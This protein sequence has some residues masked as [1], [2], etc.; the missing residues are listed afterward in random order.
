MMDKYLRKNHGNNNAVTG[1]FITTYYFE[2]RLKE[3]DDFIVMLADALINPLFNM[4]DIKRELYLMNSEVSNRMLDEKNFFMYDFL[5]EIGNKDSTIFF[6]GLN[7]QDVEALDLEKVRENV[8]AFFAKHYSANNMQLVII[9]DQNGGNL[10]KKA[11]SEFVNIPNNN[12]VREYFNTTETRIKP[13]SD[14]V[15][16]T[17][18]YRKAGTDTPSIKLVFP[19]DSYRTDSTFLAPEFFCI[20]LQYFSE[21]SFY[22]KLMQRKIVERIKCQKLLEN[23]TDAVMLVRFFEL[24]NN[25]RAYSELIFSFFEFVEQLKKST[26]LREVFG[27][28]SSLSKFSFLFNVENKKLGLAE[29]ESNL[30]LRAMEYSQNL[31]EFPNFDLFKG[32]KVYDNYDQ[33]R[34]MALLE[35]ISLKNAII[36]IENDAF[37]TK[38]DATQQS[39]QDYNQEYRTDTGKPIDEGINDLKVSQSISFSDDMNLDRSNSSIPENSN[40]QLKKIRMLEDNGSLDNDGTKNTIQLK[41]E[42]ADNISEQ[43]DKNQHNIKYE[44]NTF[45]SV[46][47]VS[48]KE[49]DSFRKEFFDNAL[50]NV[51]LTEISA[52]KLSSPFAKR[53]IPETMNDKM[54]IEIIKEDPLFKMLEPVDTSF[55]NK[56]EIIT[57]CNPP[58][59]LQEKGIKLL[60]THNHKRFEFYEE[61]S[62]AKW[63]YQL[64]NDSQ[65]TQFIKTDFLY[66]LIFEPQ[67]QNSSKNFDQKMSDMMKYKYCLEGDFTI[68]TSDKKAQIIQEENDINVWYKLYRKELQPKYV[69]IIAIKSLKYYEQMIKDP[70]SRLEIS[71]IMDFFCKYLERHL[72]L[73]FPEMFMQ[74]YNFNCRRNNFEFEFTITGVSNKLTDFINTIR[75]EIESLTNESNINM[76][77]YERLI[78]RRTQIL[79]NFRPQTA[80]KLAI[81]YLDNIMDALHVDYSKKENSYKVLQITNSIRPQIIA[82]SIINMYE[83]YKI[84]IFTCGN[85]NKEQTM[86][87]YNFFKKNLGDLTDSFD[88]L[89]IRKTREYYKKLTLK[90]N[91]NEH[92]MIRI[93]NP[94]K[95]DTNNIYLTYFKLGQLDKK[96]FMFLKVALFYLKEKFFTKFRITF[97]LGYVATAFYVDYN[98]VS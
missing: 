74:G 51:V 58:E 14:D 6:D 62:K 48:D 18:F 72:S 88:H 30:F 66:D 25:H 36:I 31:F 82:Q 1:D 16:G 78:S 33:D 2:M 92:K 68:D 54:I 89:N 52:N 32:E 90:F 71:V 4:D 91:M 63:L 27:S 13:F 45:I 11:E 96:E 69:A 35:Q 57:K 53:K 20:V 47:N 50:D 94:F 73:K 76:I 8:L 15:V 70:E 95:E 44:K 60:N 59:S 22:Y 81:Y 40:P 24:G 93:E 56:Y 10:I 67:S 21:S 85:I 55:I 38:V 87:V 80:K 77:L 83:N 17:V 98:Y 26:N 64:Y 7:H 12:I 3:Y 41:N 86:K 28:L 61:D 5:K 23:Y 42:I 43:T 49:L 29:S 84:N 79:L 39:T 97:G 34:F 9:S 46:R 75:L 65:S 19:I 37:P